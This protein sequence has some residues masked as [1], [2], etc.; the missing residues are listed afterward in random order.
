MENPNRLK[1]LFTFVVNAVN[2]GKPK[3]FTFSTHW[4]DFSNKAFE[5]NI[6]QLA[7]ICVLLDR[8]DWDVEAALK[9]VYD[10]EPSDV[11][12]LNDD[13]FGLATNGAS[14]PEFIQMLG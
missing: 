6:E 12:E 5:M 4:P 11:K 9:D 8:Q 13:Q 14:D 10:I 2:V 1:A 7:D 3:N